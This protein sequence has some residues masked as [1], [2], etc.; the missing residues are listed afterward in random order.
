MGIRFTSSGVLTTIQDA[1]R[2]GYRSVGIGPGG[3]MDEFAFRCANFLIGNPDHTAAL[4]FFYPGP[5]LVFEESGMVSLT[6]LG[7]EAELNGEQIP[8]WRPIAVSK[9][10]VL[11]IRSRIGA[12]GYLG[13]GGGIKSEEWLGSSST[14]LTARKGGFEGRAIR[15]GDLLE[16]CKRVEVKSSVVHRWGVGAKQLEYVYGSNKHLSVLPGPELDWIGPASVEQFSTQ[17]FSILP[18]SNRMGYRLS[19]NALPIQKSIQLISSPVDVGTVQ[20]LPDGQAIV[21]MADH[22]TTGG[23]PRLA[24][25]AAFDIPRL[26]QSLGHREVCFSWISMESAVELT[27]I[28]HD[29][30]EALRQGCLLNAGRYLYQ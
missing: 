8:G 9:N 15:K 21:L 10:S 28:W 14:H 24:S 23:Y 16:F 2:F 18:A 6:G 30:L 11:K 3:P 20:L 4:E 13:V 26:A 27:R 1:G 12:V 17:S 22:Q 29:T 7:I 19:S 25:V 5:E